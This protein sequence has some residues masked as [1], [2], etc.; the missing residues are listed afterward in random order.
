VELG[1]EP[2][3][4]AADEGCVKLAQVGVPERGHALHLGGDAAKVA[5]RLCL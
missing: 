1:Y 3:L 5:G 2:E 4:A